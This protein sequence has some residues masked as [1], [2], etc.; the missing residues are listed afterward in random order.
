VSEGVRPRGGFTSGSSRYTRL[1]GTE[2]P[3]T[4]MLQ[5][6]ED[7]FAIVSFPES[8]PELPASLS[9]AEAEICRMLLNGASNAEI[10]RRRRRS[11]RTI[12]N[13]V[14]SVLKKLGARSRADLPVALRRGS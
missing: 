9:S 11:E 13:Q 1:V 6:G 7:T 12:A 10:A 14:A 5:S 4:T 8:G 2:K 3:R